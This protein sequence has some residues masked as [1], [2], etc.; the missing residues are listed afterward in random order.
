MRNISIKQ[1]RAFRALQCERNFT[2]AAAS[3]FL[4]QPAF[5]ALINNLESEVGFRLF[6]R[7]TRSV[8]LTPDG[9][10]FTPIAERLLKLLKSCEQEIESIANGNQGRICIAALPSAAVNWLPAIITTYR[11]QFPKIKIS[12]IDAPSDRCLQ[13]LEDGIA[14]MA[15][16]SLKSPLKVDSDLFSAEC[17]HSEPF[18]LICDADHPLANRPD[19]GITDLAGHA[20]I[21][22]AKSTSIRQHLSEKMPTSIATDHIEVEQLTTMMGLV[23]AGLAI[24]IVPQLTLYQFNASNIVAKPIRDFDA[25]RDIHLI[26]RAD[27]TLSIAAHAFRE[28]LLKHIQGTGTN[29][30]TTE[31]AENAAWRDRRNGSHHSKIGFPIVS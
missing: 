12:L 20:I 2:R 29:A 28:L 31:I 22:F 8:R 25:R 14:D 21:Q 10:L 4:S 7:D 18:Y 16:T 17:I 11:V 15:I 5:S 9:E 3:V 24:S 23:A 30:H 27:Q 19:V 26:K 1:L 13:A 6:D